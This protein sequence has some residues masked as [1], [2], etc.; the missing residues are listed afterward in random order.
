MIEHWPWKLISKTK[1]PTKVMCFSWTALREAILTQDNLCRRNFQL[2]NRC[3]MCQQQSESVNHLFLHWSVAADLWRMF[4]SVFGISWATPQTI[5]EAVESWSL[6][7]VDRTIN[8]EDLA[9]DSS[10]HFLVCLDRKEPQ[11]F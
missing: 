10:M 9:D 5:K 3:Y 7:K 2:V 8:Q 1:I 6:W 11:M 4:L